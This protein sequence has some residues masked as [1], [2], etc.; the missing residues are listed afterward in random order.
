MFRLAPIAARFPFARINVCLRS[1][2]QLSKPRLTRCE[3]ERA[4][5][6]LPVKPVN[7]ADAESWL[8]CS[9]PA[10]LRGEPEAEPLFGNAEANRQWHQAQLCYWYG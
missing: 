6:L 2:S 10:W 4:L 8:N 7:V 3:F 5:N 9:S 1:A